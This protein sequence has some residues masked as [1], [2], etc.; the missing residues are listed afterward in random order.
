MTQ[1]LT[2]IVHGAARRLS[3]HTGRARRHFTAQ[4][5]CIRVLTY[6]GIVADEFANRPW[7][8]SHYVSVSQF[9]RQ[10]AM[11]A[12][13]GPVRPLGEALQ[14]AQAQPDAPSAVCITFDDGMADN[15]TLALPVLLKFGFRATFFL[16]TAYMDRQRYLPNDTIRMLR[17]LHRAGRL[18]QSSAILTRIFEQPG[19]CKTRSLFEYAA[20]LSAAWANHRDEVDPAA[21]ESL[22]TM[23]WHQARTLHRANMEVGAHTVNHVMLSRE[24]AD[25]RRL[26]ILESIARIRSKLGQYDV[27]FSYPNGMTGDYDAHDTDLLKAIGVPY[28]VTETPGWINSASPALELP[29]NCIG[30]HCSDRAFMAMVCGMEK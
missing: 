9:E 6:H 2:R 27:P 14:F 28:A 26:E 16:A 13:F 11:L 15:V 29:R 30:R 22:E 20:E 17:P 25:T 8:P 21:R 7:V 5:G 23:T 3:A 24:P 12:E 18:G 4:R 10:M 19:Y 1:L